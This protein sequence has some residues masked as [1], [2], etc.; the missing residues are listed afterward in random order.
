[1]LELVN[2]ALFIEMMFEEG[3]RLLVRLIS[4]L[5]NVDYLTLDS[6]EMD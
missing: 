4:Y 1:M 6:G 2:L 5:Q 3:G